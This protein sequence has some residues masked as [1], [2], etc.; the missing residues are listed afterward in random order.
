[1]LNEP[2]WN[3]ASLVTLRGNQSTRAFGLKWLLAP[4]FA[5]C[6]TEWMDSQSL[7]N[8]CEHWKAPGRESFLPASIHAPSLLG[9]C[10]DLQLYRFGFWISVEIQDMF[11]FSHL[12]YPRW[13]RCSSPTASGSQ[14]SYIWPLKFI[15]QGPLRLGRKAQSCLWR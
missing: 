15:V 11:E 4:I 12:P 6:P 8:N 13:S 1:M 10:R 2:D 9:S 14:N 7:W 5:P 3:P